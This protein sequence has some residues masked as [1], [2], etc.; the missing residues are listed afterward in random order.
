MP[1]HDLGPRLRRV[2]A[3][4]RESILQ[5][6]YAA[7]TTL[8]AYTKLAEQ[9]GVS[10][11]T[12]RHALALLEQERLVSRQQGRGTFVQSHIPP[13]VLI[14]DDDAEMRSLLRAFT[15][16]A[17][18]RVAEAPSPA[19][20]LAILN[21]DQAIAL[22]LADVRIPDRACGI[23]LLRTM[24]RRWP[25]L[26]VAAITGYPDDLAELHGTPECPVLILAKPVREQQIQEVFR[27]VLGSSA[28][29]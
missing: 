9:F 23:A 10:A 3:A 14:V 12:I 26:P 16:Q 5:G 21:A 11:V 7:G 25:G 18:Y 20:A 24:Y 17:G 27:W 13:G 4:L 29:V 22:V 15:T 6:D 1:N 28:P 19:R 2:H 8:P